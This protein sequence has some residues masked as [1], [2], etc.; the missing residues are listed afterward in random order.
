M[1]ITA[2]IRDALMTDLRD[3]NGMDG[4]VTA[5]AEVGSEPKRVDEAQKPGVYVQSTEGVSDLETIT[6]RRGEVEQI[7]TLDLVVSSATPNAD[8]DALLDDVRNAIERDG[9]NILTVSAVT[10]VTVTDWSPVGTDPDIA[11]GVYWRT[12]NVAVNYIYTRGAA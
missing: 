2:T 4:F 8:M 6:Q 5:L 12:V 9:S 3:I 1:S 7:Y 11:L 10:K